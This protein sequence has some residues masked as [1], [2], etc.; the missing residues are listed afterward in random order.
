[1]AQGDLSNVISIYTAGYIIA[2]IPTT[3]MLLVVRPSYWFPF[4]GVC[5]AALTCC[6]AAAKTGRAIYAIRF[7]QGAFESICFSGAMFIMGSWYR[8][9]EIAKRTAIFCVSGHLGSVSASLIQ[10]AIHKNLS[11]STSLESWRLMFVIDGV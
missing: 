3:L 9:D 1:M 8:A 7:C 2:Q 6:C 10:S 11:G 4:N 5:W